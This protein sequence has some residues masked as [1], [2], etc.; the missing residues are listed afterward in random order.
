MLDMNVKPLNTYLL[1]S[2]KTSASDNKYFKHTVCQGYCGLDCVEIGARLSL[3]LLLNTLQVVIR[4]CERITTIPIKIISK[5]C[6]TEVKLK[7]LCS[8]SLLLLY[9]SI[10]KH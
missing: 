6:F 1:N 9:K 4:L 8:N 3:C 5:S 2:N 7:V 10:S